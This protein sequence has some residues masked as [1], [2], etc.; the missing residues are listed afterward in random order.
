MHRIS[1]IQYTNPAAYPPLEHSSRILADAGW[2]VLFLGVEM[3]NIGSLQFP[4]HSNIAIRQL[5]LCRPGWRQKLHYTRYVFWAMLHSLFWR[6][7]WIYASDKFACPPGLLL[8]YMPGI[9]VIYHEHDSPSPVNGRPDER[10]CFMRIILWTRRQLARRAAFCILPNEKR[11]ERFRQDIG[12]GAQVKCVWNCPRKTEVQEPHPHYERK[13]LWI[14]YHGSL[15]P[16]RLPASVIEALS[17]AQR[18]RLRIIGYETPGHQ[19]YTGRLRKLAEELGVVNRVE[20]I[21]A[22]PRSN[23][24]DHCHTGDVGLAFMPRHSD[25]FN[26]QSMTGASNKPFDYLACGLALLVSDLPEWR[27][28]YVDNGYAMAVDPDDAKAIA[29]ALDWLQ[30]HPS[31]MR[32]MGERGRQ[33]ILAEWNYE[34]Q[35]ARILALL[36]NPQTAN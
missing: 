10:S 3:E 31:E 6:S 4:R 23:S 5:P 7:S 13:D 1:Y 12:D 36:G 26:E 25:D 14:V 9:R 27:A 2:R 28:L 21:G 11:A 30:K 15:V 35:F 29:A 22:V 17:L 33:R 20:F 34:T 8:S 16:A 18:V 19:G 24:L 32:A